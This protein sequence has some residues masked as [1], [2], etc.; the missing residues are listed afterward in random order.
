[1]SAV[2]LTLILC[3]AEA[4]SMAGTFAFPGLLPVFFEEWAIS[5]TEAGWIA[6][7][8]YGGYTAA[9][10]VLMSLTDRIDAR[11]VY[12]GGALVG[13]AGYLGFALFAAG[14]WSALGWWT[15]AG[16]GLAG[17]YMP[18]LR[19]LVDRL[20]RDQ[21]SRAVAFY[22]SS[23]SLG[24]ALSFA[25]AG[26]AGR[27]WGWRAPFFIGAAGAVLAAAIAFFVLKPARPA[28]PE[29]PTPLFDFGPVLRNRRA[30]GYVLG[31]GVHTLELFAYRSWLVAFLAFSLTLSASPAFLQPT[32]V[33]MIAALVAMVSS[34]LG[35]EVAARF[36][37]QRIISVVMGVA[38]AI[39][40]GFGYTAPLPFAAV[41]SVALVYAAVIQADSAAL[42]AGV[43]AVADP[44]RRGATLA[45]HSVVG[46]AGAFV[47]PLAL[48]VVLDLAGGAGRPLAWG[49]GFGLIGLFSLVEI[50]AL[51][52]SLRGAR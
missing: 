8:F 20:G 42:T 16:M 2:R 13:A 22:T 50:A 15:L 17:T 28:R 36:G 37:R 29:E 32:V 31:Y 30:M 21:E 6:G 25:L 48:G 35:Q 39:A 47:G 33:A 5:T 43:V 23:F 10:P 52:W 19:A 11:R 38:M 46:F 34:V 26:E 41:V 27:A 51:F 45:V 1:M 18:G 7:I 3:A 24:T 40:F 44:G 49:L 14:F 4:L 9:V 12:I